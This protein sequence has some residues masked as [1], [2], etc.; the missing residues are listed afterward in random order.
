[1]L[2]HLLI[3]DKTLA[4]AVISAL[5]AEEKADQITPA[6]NPIDLELS[7]ALRLYG[8]TKPTL[9]GK[10]VGLLLGAGFNPKLTKELVSHI[11]N[12]GAK[13][14]LVITKIQGEL[15]SEG[16]LQ[17]G[18]MALRASPPVLF[19]A[20]VI[21]AGPDGDKKL[22]ADPNALS[23]LMDAKR[24][25]KAAGLSGIPSLSK[26]AG[27]EKEPGILEITDTSAIKAFIAAATAGRFWER[28]TE[29]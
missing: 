20:V 15:D 16:Q 10:K 29:Q 25:C 21:L 12:A 13:A 14:V 18:D 4:N 19:D 11:K 5:G 23:F 24:H 28:E 9:M 27:V 17:A 7:P 3:I 8:K 2:G 6:K 22:T 1:M 26:K